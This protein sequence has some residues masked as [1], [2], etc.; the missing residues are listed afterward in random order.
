M[1]DERAALA[2]AERLKMRVSDAEVRLRILAIPAFQENGAFIGADRY[3][4]LLASQNPPMSST[5]TAIS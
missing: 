5:M 2:E 4:Q 1:V 3:Q